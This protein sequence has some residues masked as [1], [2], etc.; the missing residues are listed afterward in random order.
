M[1]KSFSRLVA[2]LLILTFLVET[3]A[4]AVAL[5][6]YTDGLTNCG[7]GVYVPKD[8]TCPSTSDPFFFACMVLASAAG[9]AAAAL[10]AWWPPFALGA[11]GL[12]FAAGAALCPRAQPPQPDLD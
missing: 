6:V 3:V 12:A 9:L 1:K 10:L 7:G 5:A 4:P 2:A 8:Q 11:F